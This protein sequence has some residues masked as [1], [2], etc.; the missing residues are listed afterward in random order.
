VAALQ[1][2]D[3]D[4]S[5]RDKL[6]GMVGS[7]FDGERL[8]ALGM[9][10][11]MAGN[12][13]VPI[14]GLLLGEGGGSDFDRQRAER[15]ERAANEANLRAQR[16]EQARLEA[17]HARPAESDPPKPKLPPDWRKLFV[18]AQQLNGSW[19]FLTAFHRRRKPS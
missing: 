7:Q 17:Q 3:A 18:E 2:S 12:Y 19:F 1:L 5:R 9:L 13:K 8:N 6:V 4:R 14:H 11:R 16:A 15:A 10:Q